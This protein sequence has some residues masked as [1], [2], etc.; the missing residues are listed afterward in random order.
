[1]D[2]PRPAPREPHQTYFD[3]I[4]VDDPSS[5]IFTMVQ[6]DGPLGLSPAPDDAALVAQEGTYRWDSASR[7]LRVHPY[8]NR[9][10]SAS[11][12]DLVVALG[13]N[14]IHVEAKVQYNVFDGFRI[15]Y[16][17][18][19]TFQV[20]GNNNRFLNLNFQ[21]VPWGLRGTNNYAR[22]HHGHAC[23]QSRPG[24]AVASTAAPARRWS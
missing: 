17:T 22:E 11:G 8:G 1:M 15:A 18:A 2:E 16:G 13:G 24:V 7:L 12:T 10:P 20:N 19:S 9:V 21:G 23:D 4:L 5:S 3:P 6:E 14:S